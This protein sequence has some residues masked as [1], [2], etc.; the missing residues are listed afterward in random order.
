MQG[1]SILQYKDVFETGGPQRPKD[2]TLAPQGAFDHHLG[3]PKPVEG[4]SLGPDAIFDC[5][6]S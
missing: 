4:L 3:V 2:T 5:Q 1:G 6:W